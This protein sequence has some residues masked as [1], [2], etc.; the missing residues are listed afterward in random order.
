MTEDE[1]GKA[2]CDARWQLVCGALNVMN[3]WWLGTIGHYVSHVLV[4]MVQSP[5]PGDRAWHGYL[6]N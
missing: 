6:L 5:Q 2:V 4:M 1:R 3:C